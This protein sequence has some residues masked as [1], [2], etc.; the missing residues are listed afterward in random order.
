M[1]R[2]KEENTEYQRNRRAK[3]AI[4]AAQQVAKVTAS[5]VVE[6]KKVIKGVSKRNAAVVVIEDGKAAVREFSGPSGYHYLT[7]DEIIGQMTQKQRD[8]ILQ[9]M[10]KTA[11]RT[12]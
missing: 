2:T 7:G 1:T 5:E 11:S 10:P 12:R 8:A 9:K 3:N 6:A 4:A